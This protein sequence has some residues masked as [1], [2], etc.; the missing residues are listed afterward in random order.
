MTD[1]TVAPKHHHHR[2]PHPEDAAFLRE[3]LT[4]APPPGPTADVY[5]IAGYVDGLVGAA[6]PECNVLLPHLDSG[7]KW[8]D[9]NNPLPEDPLWGGGVRA[10]VTWDGTFYRDLAR[11][12]SS[13]PRFWSAYLKPGSAPGIKKGFWLNFGSGWAH[14]ANDD[15]AQLAAGASPRLYF[16]GAANEWRLVIEATLFVTGAVVNVWTGSKSGG[17]DP[18]G[19]YT[20][21]SGCDP[22]ATLAVV[23]A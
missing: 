23:A 12:A 9:K 8:P 19:T 22:V 17:A 13:G 21:I 16:V 7:L 5:R 18:V 4:P 20:R 3:V 2:H 15:P 1:S 6:K 10:G 14:L 11:Y